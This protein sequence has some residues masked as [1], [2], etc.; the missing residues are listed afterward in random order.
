MRV[1]CKAGL[2]KVIK[3]HQGEVQLVFKIPQVEASQVVLIPEETELD[4]T[5]EW[6]E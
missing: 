4:L 3:D 1:A 6:R 5:V 2:W